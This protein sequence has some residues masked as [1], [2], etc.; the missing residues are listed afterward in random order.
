MNLRRCRQYV[1][2][3]LLLGAFTSARGEIVLANY[4]SNNP[5]KIMCI[6][7]SITDDC[8]FNGAWRAYLQPLLDNAGYPFTFVGRNH[9]SANPPTFTK[10]AHEGYCGSVIAPPGVTTAVYGYA[11]T[12][13]DL[14]FI[15]PDA[16]AANTPDI[17]LLL[18]GANDIGRGRDP[19]TVASNDFPNLLN[20][21][22]SIDPHVNI[23][24]A[25]I[26]SLSGGN[27]A[28][29]TPPY[30]TYSGNVYKY[31]AY[32]QN[33]INQRRAQGQNVWLSDMFSVVNPTNM[34]MGD[35]VH[36]NPAGLQAMAQEWFTRIQAMTIA[37]NQFTS[38]LVH[39]GDT[40]SYNDTGQ[41][42][43]TNWSQPGYDDSTWSNG[44]ARLG[45]NDVTDNTTVS[46][47]GNVTNRYITTYFLH[48]IVVPPHAVITN[49]QFRVQRV[50]GDVTYF[51]GL[52]VYRSNMP[53]GPITYTNLASS[54]P[55]FDASYT[56]YPATHPLATPIFGTHVAA[57]EVHK[58]I[59][60]K[61]IMTFD[62]EV[63]GMG[64][65]IPT[66]AIAINS[67]NV[68]LSWPVNSSASFSLWAAPDATSGM[69]SNTFAT[70]QTNGSTVTATVP[71]GPATQF[72]RLQP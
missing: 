20:E 15:V 21:I 47:G 45:Y 12:N 34:F 37:T 11:G 3:A 67:G 10:T 26:T 35:H 49:L 13:V 44:L 60:T 28:G 38:T 52:E 68:L 51:D 41:N 9:S 39:G 71:L 66:P 4:S 65:Y 7:D 59:P 30:G 29:I 2:C 17:I 25:K 57:V 22:F 24:C 46:F 33:V 63:I 42:L 58:V 36:P 23:I 43:G 32:L 6:G 55:G 62:A 69:W 40:W 1:F 50:D 48:P 56:F 61:G 16:L 64:Y 70:M 5:V 53:L 8:E 18:I 72:F 27:I 54:G 14:Q 31:N 19:G